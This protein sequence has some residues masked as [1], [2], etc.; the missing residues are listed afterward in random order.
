M[1]KDNE[2]T[3]TLLLRASNKLAEVLIFQDFLKSAMAD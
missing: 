3:E 2:N 1:S